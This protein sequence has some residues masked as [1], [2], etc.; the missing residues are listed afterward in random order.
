MDREQRE[1]MESRPEMMVADLARY[2]D[3]FDEL[4]LTVWLDGGWGVDA[5]LGEQTRPHQ[6]LDIVIQKKETSVLCEALAEFG[7]EDVETDDHSDWN[8][9]VGNDK[10]HRIDFHVI[11]IDDQGRGVYGPPEKNDVFPAAALKGTG[12][13][14]GR[15][16][17]CL[18]PEYQVQSHTGYEID[19]GDVRDVMALHRRFGVPLPTEYEGCAKKRS[20]TADNEPTHI[21]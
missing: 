11:E 9:V 21:V 17:R 19:E 6:D 7:F 14:N 8:F 15:A 4:G 20:H 2:I 5:L 16:V 12:T 1:G 10:G 13:I 18:S 3:L